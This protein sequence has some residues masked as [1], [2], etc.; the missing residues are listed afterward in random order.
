MLFIIIRLGIDNLQDFCQQNRKFSAALN[1]N[2]I[3]TNQQRVSSF[4][5]YEFI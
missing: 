4:S 3:Y 2:D 1:S 5:Y